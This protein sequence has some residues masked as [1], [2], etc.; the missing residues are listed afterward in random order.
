M[1]SSYKSRPAGRY[2]IRNSFPYT[3]WNVMNITHLQS[4]DDANLAPGDQA[5]LVRL[6]LEGAPEAIYGIDNQGNATFC[7]AACLQMLGYASADELLGRNM[8]KMVHHSKADGSAYPVEECQIYAALRSGNATH[9]DNDALWRKDG[10]RI[11]VECWSRPI[12]R[13]DA[14]IGSV[15]TFIDVGERIEAARVLR[16]AKEAAE[17]ASRA[18]SEFLANMSHEM[19]TPLNG[20]IG[21]TDLALET[22]LTSEQREMLDTVKLSADSLLSVINDV[23][24]FSKIEAGRYELD[25]VDFDLPDCLHSTL[26]TLALRANQKGLELLCDLGADIP[27]FVRGDPNR[28][29][30]IIINLV[31]NAIKFTAKGEI[32]VRV[33]AGAT[34][35]ALCP[36]QFTVADT[37][38]G[39]PKDKHESIFDAFTQVDSATTRN[40][41]GTGLGLTICA[42][43]TKLMGGRIW[44]ESEP[45]H[46]SRFHFAVTLPRGASNRTNRSPMRPRKP[47]DGVKALIVDDNLSNRRI[48]TGMLNL[49]GMRSA[50]VE[51]GPGAITA[52]IEAHH[53]RDPFAL[54][55]TDMH[56]PD[57]DGF[58]LIERIQDNPDL[59]TAAIMMLTSG[60]QRGDLERCERL[61]VAAYL[62][63]PVRQME[64][65]KSILEV[66]GAANGVSGHATPAPAPP[67]AVTRPLRILIAEDNPVNQL[68]ATRLLEKRGHSVRIAANGLL[69]LN[70]LAE[71][72]F[73]LVFM[74]LQM[75]ELDGWQAIAAI[76]AG[77]GITG[78]HLKV[79]ALTAH[80][81]TGDRERCLAAGM[82]GYLAKPIRPEECDRLLAEFAVPQR[83]SAAMPVRGKPVQ[84]GR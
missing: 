58:D 55:L 21:M 33:E 81:M 31:G 10:T 28:L 40:Y 83:Q 11:L 35:G 18:K 54:I 61:G 39:I 53:D 66:L 4:R 59:R 34:Q 64:L 36:L 62:V 60:G 52:L 51:D 45:G 82:D 3:R 73:D 46:G 13:A 19:R 29:R 5:E 22:P 65:R 1:L 56:M 15:V 9:M 27:Q 32:T 84:I 42:R 16:A 67:P 8:H 7:N 79:V 23:L 17:A 26:R 43:L 2:P 6:L 44:V 37:G 30:Q 20:I 25:I 72:S 14:I 50:A 49:W 71:E 24:D 80:A 63:K 69:A 74:D 76:R 38:I 47:C 57:M 78:R 70:A 41:G 77:E 68:V 12:H 48:L 75:P